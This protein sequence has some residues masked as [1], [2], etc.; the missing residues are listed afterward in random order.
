[1]DELELLRRKLARERKAREEAERLIEEK[2]LDIYRA[3]LAAEVASR[4]KTEFLA[5]MSHELRTPI[6]I[7][8]GFAEV[9]VSGIA[10]PLSEAQK[11]Y[12]D[13]I[14]QSGNRLQEVFQQVLEMA[15]LEMDGAQ[16]EFQ[17]IDFQ[18]VIGR[19]LDRFAPRAEAKRLTFEV[20]VADGIDMVW[21]D[22]AALHRIL[23]SLLDNAIKF[24]ETPGTIGISASP[25]ERG[26]VQI[27]VADHGIGIPAPDIDRVLEPFVQADGGLARARE[28]AGLGLAI[29]RGLAQAMGGSLTLAS[30]VGVGTR[31]SVYLPAADGPEAE[32][33]TA[34]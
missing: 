26:G 16:L 13:L 25:A 34:A 23:S 9:L 10:G 24:T 20:S 4:T 28:G 22:P 19:S 5:N 11:E 30:T 7:I 2:S 29:A 27:D 33:H 8:N 15:R 31:A 18:A 21:G 32:A 14:M 12:V 1:V 6:N 17:E 3:K